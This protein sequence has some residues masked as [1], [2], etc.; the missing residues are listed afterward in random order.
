MSD[1]ICLWLF[2]PPPQMYTCSSLHILVRVFSCTQSTLDNNY[3]KIVHTMIIFISAQ[4]VSICLKRS[5]QLFVDT[6]SGTYTCSPLI[7]KP[8]AA[9]LSPFLYTTSYQCVRRMLMQSPHC[10]MCK[11]GLP[12]QKPIHPNFTCEF[13]V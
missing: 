7:A 12:P 2:K 9:T 13:G 5:T 3:H 11:A 8:A 10:P 4:S 1:I 6:V